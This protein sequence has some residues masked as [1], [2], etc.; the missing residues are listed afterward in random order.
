MPHVKAGEK[1][2]YTTQPE[3]V[4]GLIEEHRKDL[5]VKETKVALA[6]LV[7]RGRAQYLA[8]KEAPKG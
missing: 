2:L 4:H 6:D 1:P 8:E 5:G 7:R 3:D